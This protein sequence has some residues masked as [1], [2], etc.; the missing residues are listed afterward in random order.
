MQSSS[1]LGEHHHHYP[2]S[3]LSNEA[4]SSDSEKLKQRSSPHC[5]GLLSNTTTSPSSLSNSNGHETASANGSNTHPRHRF[6]SSSSQTLLTGSA[7]P[8]NNGTTNTARLFTNSE[9]EVLRLIGQHLQSVGL[10]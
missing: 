10:G 5:N 4:A 6:L 8:F 3:T 1:H 2:M 9:K 7:Y